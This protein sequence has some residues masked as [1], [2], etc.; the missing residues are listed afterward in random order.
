LT[1]ILH[2]WNF[3]V[4]WSVM[5][6]IFS[7][8]L[9]A[10]A[11]C[12]IAGATSY[13]PPRNLAD[14]ALE[15]DAVVLVEAVRSGGID[16][17]FLIFT[18]TDFLVLESVSGGL[19]SGEI[20]SVQVQG[21]EAA[22]RTCRVPGSPRFQLE[23]VYL[24]FLRRKST[25]LWTPT[26]LSHGN[27]KRVLGKSGTP[28]LVPLEESLEAEII[29]RPD[30]ES[31]ETQAP[32][33]EDALIQHL[34]KVLLGVTTWD[35]AKTLADPAEVPVQAAALAAPSEC[36]YFSSSG[37][38]WRWRTFDTGGTATIYA[39]STGDPSEP[40][41]GFRRIQEGLDLWMGITGTSLN[42]LFGGARETTPVCG[43]QGGF[44]LFDDPCSDIPDLS[45][46]GGTLAFGGASSSGTHSFEGA[47][48]VTITNW[49]VVMNNGVG[50]LGTSN[51]Q[52]LLAHELGHGLG[53]NHSQDSGSIMWATCCRSI[54]D[55]DRTCTRYT[56]PLADASNERPRADAGGDRSVLLVG[57]TTLL[58]GTASD[59][60]RP[61]PGNLTTTWKS[62]AGPGTVT[63]EDPSALETAA[64]F[65][66]SGTYLLGLVAHDGILLHMD[67]IQVEVDIFAGS[68]PAVVFQQGRDGY[69][70]TVDTTLIEDLPG[71]IQSGSSL[72]GVDGDDPGGSGEAVQSLLRFDD[73]F[74]S[75]PGQII[76]GSI[77]RS[78]RLELETADPGD[79]AALHR[80][81]VP[82]SDSDSW[83]TFGGD[84]IQVDNG[85]ALSREEA[86]VV[87]TDG[88]VS[89]DV[90]D[91]LAAWSEDPC[92]NQGWVLLPLG[93]DG[94]D[95]YSSEGDVPPRLIVE[96]A[97]LRREQLIRAG[98]TWTYFK[99]TRAPPGDW[100]EV[101]FTTGPEWLSGPTGI[102]YG[103]GDDATIL[104]DMRNSYR[105]IFC[106]REFTVR[107]PVA[108][109]QLQIDYDD[110]FVAYLNG[111]EVARSENLGAPGTPVSWNT[112]ASPTH[113]AGTPEEYALPAD[114]ILQGRNVLAVEIHNGSLSSSDLSFI[115]E[116]AASFEVIPDGS[117]WRFLRGSSPIPAGWN[118]PGFDDGSWEVGRTGIG[119]GDGDDLTVLDDMR[120]SYLT[121]FCRHSFQIQSGYRGD[122]LLTVIY[123][124]GLVIYL[125]GEELD[126]V[127][128]PFGQ[129]TSTT[130][131]MSAIEPQAFTLTIPGRLL[132]EGENVLAVSV[133]N[134]G[135]DSSDLSFNPIL[136]PRPEPRSVFCGTGFQRGDA[137]SDGTVD[138]SDSIRLLFYLFREDEQLD[139]LDAGDINDDG[140][141]DIS[142]AIYLLEYLYLDGQSPPPPGLQCGEDPT[143]DDLPECATAGCDRP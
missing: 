56:Y 11:L 44:I 8:A 120:G 132:L 31:A 52:I 142:D 34:R 4:P 6:K 104:G 101:D 130:V 135:L 126:R 93:E 65:P 102:G 59:D 103:D 60:G 68:Q 86:R 92:S 33:R 29:P 99:G 21:G 119:Y 26:I 45:G 140:Q 3:F 28:L 19:P 16:R 13:I 27:L 14:L 91:S 12:G 55:T 114:L 51:Y 109:L 25:D 77:I 58:R 49:F 47:S 131:A 1:G 81:V 139:C 82:W 43:G 39:N 113:E 94:W 61:A 48:W 78:A 137:S 97:D 89:I 64:T 24:L 71:A 18:N 53:Y 72:L 118:Q 41:L 83:S 37:M 23:A 74:G 63:F 106:R 84:G 125:N 67:Q 116:L 62:L 143:P 96:P 20:I 15:S 32:L 87:G 110:G 111:E 128:M 69:V 108:S 46:C 123:D 73:I 54:N 124:D 10:V 107:G 122:L 138:I 129:V 95:F 7:G 127:N 17:G 80:M 85:E 70:G 134:A 105:S 5:R 66:S 9:A 42:L 79:G 2:G 90:T 35:L 136:F 117:R 141:V 88:T 133:H 76:P 50:C 22:Q 40:T 57:N 100:R 115:P 121:V 98:D 38:N 36:E 75:G 30:G 112:L